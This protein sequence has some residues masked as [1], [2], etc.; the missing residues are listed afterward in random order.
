MKQPFMRMRGLEPIT[1]AVILP[2]FH[3]L[4]EMEALTSPFHDGLTLISQ[5]LHSW[6]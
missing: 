5:I 6:G 4:E 2:S 3:P 1:L